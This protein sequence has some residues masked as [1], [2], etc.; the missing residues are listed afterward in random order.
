VARGAAVLAAT[1]RTENS[2]TLPISQG[3]FRLELEHQPVGDDPEPQIGGKVVAF[4]GRNVRNFTVEFVNRDSHWRSGKLPVSENGVFIG[5]LRAEKGRQNTFDIK[6]YDSTGI[7]VSAV[8]S[9]INYTI[10]L[11][12]A[13]QPLIH[14]VG[15]ALADNGYKQLFEK[16]GPLPLKRRTTHKQSYHVHKGAAGEAVIIPL[17]EGENP[18]ADRNPLIG[19]LEI[20]S[21]SIRRDIPGGSEV[22]ITVEIDSSRQVRTKAYTPILDEEIERIHVL[23]K[24]EPA[25]EELVRDSDRESRRLSALQ[26]NL[27]EIVDPTARELMVKI[28]QEQ[29]Q[30][31]VASSL[32]AA[33]VDRDAADQCQKI[34]IPNLFGCS[35]TG[36]CLG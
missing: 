34:A 30:A 12:V 27:E 8:P 7:Q 2:K 5:S 15:L 10:G 11:V 31:Q 26:E 9:S 17:V 13:D 1:Q 6:L 36:S 18:R 14:S 35:L 19:R 24:V 32:A 23:T 4:D 3:Q 21:T 33:N 16:G 29:I 25:L 22:E 28:G 20:P